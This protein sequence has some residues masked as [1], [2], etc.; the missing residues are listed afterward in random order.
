MKRLGYWI[1]DG[2]DPTGD[3]PSYSEVELWYSELAMEVQRKLSSYDW[4]KL[5]GHRK[6]EVSA[7]AKT[8][9]TLRDK[10]RRDRSTPLSSV[11]DIAGV[12]F[13]AEMTLSQQ[14]AVAAEIARMYGQESE[15]AIHDLRSSPH[16][17]YRAVHVWLRL[18]ARVEVQVRTRSQ[19]VW[20]NAYESLADLVGRNIRL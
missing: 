7:R 4:R 6:L 16:S 17:G 12:R 20:A 8:V 19:G 15:H 1:R 9:D 2:G 3:F 14:T 18:P 11:Q 5:L 10:L 13:E